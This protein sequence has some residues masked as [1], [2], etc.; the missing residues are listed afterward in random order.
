MYKDGICRVDWDYYTKT[1]YF[2]DVNYQ[3]AKND[4]KAAI[5]QKYC[6][7]HNYFTDDISVQ[8]SFVSCKAERDQYNVNIEIPNED[9]GFNYVRKEFR[10]MLED[11][12]ERGNNGLIRNK[13]LTLGIHSLSR[14][15]AK[16][17]LEHLEREVISN[18]KKVGVTAAYALSGYDRLELL[19][20]NF[21]PDVSDQF[22]FDWDMRVKTGLSTKDFIAPPSFNFSEKNICKFGDTYA[23]TVA[24]QILA[25]EIS[26]NMLADFLKLE[27]SI[28]FNI[29]LH[30]MEQQKA[31]A[32]VKRKGSS[33]NSMKIDEQKKAARSGYDIDILPPDI[34][35]YSEEIKRTLADLQSRNEHLFYC[36][37][38]I[39]MYADTV[40]EIGL[41]TNQIKG[42]I[43]KHS[44]KM[45]PLD[46]QQEEALMSAIPLG[47]NFVD[48][49]ERLLTTVAI[50][51]FLPFTTQELYQESN[52]AL[53][54]GL[55]AIS[56]NMIL[57]DRKQL[58]N[59]NGLILGTP[60]SG[61]SFAGKREMFNVFLV[62][63]DDII[64]ND[65][66]GEY[67]PL[68]NCLGG[69]VIKIS[70]NS[71]QFIN[72]MDINLNYADDGDP[73]AQKSDFIL[74]MCE[75]I[76]GG[77]YGLEPIERSVIDR[78]V[79]KVYDTY[80]HDPKPENMPI[81]QDLY[82]LLKKS[83][84]VGEHVADNLELYVTGSLNLFNHRTNV[85]LDNRVI[86]YDIKDLGKNLRKLG[87]F[88]VQDQV[89]NKVTANRENYKH[90]WY[91]MDEF[92]LLL[93]DTQTSKYSSDIWKR[94]RKFRGIPTGLTQ[95][96][97]DLLASPDIAT[98]FNN[99]EFIYLLNQ[100]SGD[101][102]ILAEELDISEY[103]L[104]H[105]TDVTA[106]EG[107]IK[108][109]QMMLPFVD[110]FPKDTE[111]YRI[112][113]TNPNDITGEK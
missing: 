113:T 96:V 50:S 107:L 16:A 46:W 30:S 109:G 27:N 81:L 110:K 75:I 8:F 2:N 60:G 37:L 33:V 35:T 24:I 22:I 62:T 47:K 31:I 42:I 53:Y 23:S 40:K 3:L 56:N 18:L 105:V 32:Y 101:R 43:Q 97:T 102:K 1:I 36:T 6:D 99:S 71:K 77:K 68:V 87:M 85:D 106:G 111:L 79:R 78:C 69:Q 14:K 89:W 70:S 38:T 52:N 15:E 82:D 51:V 28:S 41:L 39:T 73:I 104:S 26:D 98:I 5:F 9:D 67:Y 86:C 17:K 64:I 49:Q 95:N 21:N 112:M 58:K 93:K 76:V 45:L 72:P 91:Y 13:Y 7:L 54:Y 34:Q 55:N 4:D 74:S 90:T 61:K 83:G 57:C 19:H 63:N 80:F 25:S 44:C 92:H 11:Q 108:Y 103:Q 100:S 12:L 84:D 88:I 20:R 48:I 10:D 29:H 94:F 66:E 59:P 65:P